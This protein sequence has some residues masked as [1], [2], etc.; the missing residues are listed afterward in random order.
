MFPL[1]SMR[2]LQAVAGECAFFTEEQCDTPI[3]DGDDDVVDSVLSVCVDSVS[4]VLANGLVDVSPEL[5]NT[6]AVEG[7]DA[8]DASDASVCVAF[9]TGVLAN[10]L[11][12]VLPELY[13]TLAV[14]GDDAVNASGSSVCVATVPGG[15]VDDLVA[16]SLGLVSASCLSDVFPTAPAA[17]AEGNVGE[18]LTRGLD[19]A[20][21]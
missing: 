12:V 18:A 3:V 4:G 21:L 1:E 13:D 7:D 8:V 11:V 5:C 6:L 9:V 14:E 16:V 15:F 2:A 20:S 19:V 10:G 17:T